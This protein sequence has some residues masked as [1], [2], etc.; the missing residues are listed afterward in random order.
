MVEKKNINM[1][2]VSPIFYFCIDIK[3]IF[4]LGVETKNKDITCTRLIKRTRSEE[5]ISGRWLEL[6]LELS[7][8][9]SNEMLLMSC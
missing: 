6:S 2:K 9:D 5:A 4:G 1:L 3:H 8:L 7:F